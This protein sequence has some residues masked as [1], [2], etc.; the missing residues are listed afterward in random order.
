M[1][2][3]VNI[4]IMR[5]NQDSAR[6]YKWDVVLS[7]PGPGN[8]NTINLRCTTL[9]EPQPTYNSADVNIRGFTKRESG[10]IDW[11][12][13]NFTVIEVVSY[14]VLNTLW[15]WGQKQFHNRTGIQQ[16][17]VNY[18]GTI[19]MALLNLQD[20]V[21]KTWRLYGCVLT[22]ISMP[23]LVSDKAT[24]TEVNFTVQYDFADLL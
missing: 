16:N 5:T 18:E 1:S 17:K 19:T 2:R 20:N 14:D 11:N 4:D 10:A 3:M 21:I 7:G 6:A 13:I 9:D 23:Q 12:D 22:N 8:A 24:L 15:N